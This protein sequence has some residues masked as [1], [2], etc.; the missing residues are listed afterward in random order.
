MTE[1]LK[2]F[3]Y[4]GISVNVN[5]LIRST[6]SFCVL[7]LFFTSCKMYKQDLMFQ[8]DSDFSENDLT[9]AVIKAEKNYV[10]QKNDYLRID[11]F[12]NGGERIIDPN[13]EL[14]QQGGGNFMNQQNGQRNFQYLLQEDGMVKLPILGVV[15]LEGLTIFEAEAKLEQL[16]NQYYKGTFVKLQFVNKRVIVLGANGG[17]V[18]PLSNEKMSLLEIIAISGGINGNAKAQNVR[19]IRGPYSNPEVFQIDL[20]NVSSI[21][22]GLTAV[23]PGDVIYIEPWK[24]PV[25]QSLRDASP[26][27][28]I[29]S[30]VLTLYLVI[31]NL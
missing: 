10:I 7:L 9:Q 24:R 8:L 16:F 6:L 26:I 17:Q 23:E 21:K 3:E 18:I 4:I 13:F 30:S 29:I 31:Q 25:Q 5:R 20:S 19:L 2:N 12:T 1:R 15:P 27:I 14:V 28:S 22:T 11:V